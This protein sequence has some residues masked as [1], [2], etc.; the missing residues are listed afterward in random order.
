MNQNQRV[1]IFD[2][3]NTLLKVGIFCDGNLIG[4]DSFSLK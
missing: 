2:A 4:T 3:G 1:L